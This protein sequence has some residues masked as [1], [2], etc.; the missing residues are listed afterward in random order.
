MGKTFAVL[1]TNSLDIDW[2]LNFDRRKFALVPNSSI[3]NL[4]QQAPD[5]LSGQRFVLSTNHPKIFPYRSTPQNFP[6]LLYMTNDYNK[7]WRKCITFSQQFW[8]RHLREFIPTMARRRKWI[9]DK[10][11]LEVSHLVWILE[12]MTPRGIWPLDIL[13]KMFH[14]IVEKIRSCKI[15]S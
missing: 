11:P 4:L 1:K 13:E 2:L 14:S 9:K 7:D 12:D 3:R 15:R 6:S 8:T 10:K 5:L